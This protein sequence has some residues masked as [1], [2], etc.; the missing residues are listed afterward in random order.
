[1]PKPPD[2]GTHLTLPDDTAVLPDLPHLQ[3]E[4]M[5]EMEM[6][7][8]SYWQ[9]ETRAPNGDERFK[10]PPSEELQ[11]L[12][13]QAEEI[14][15]RVSRWETME[16]QLGRDRTLVDRAIQRRDDLWKE[17]FTDF[18]LDPPKPH[19]E[20]VTKQRNRV[21]VVNWTPELARPEPTQGVAGD[22]PSGDAE[23][24]PP[25]IWTRV[26]SP[27]VGPLGPAPP[28][29]T[30]QAGGPATGRG[31]AEAAMSGAETGPTTSQAPTAAAG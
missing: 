10:G 19:T 18:N 16:G 31:R 9:T 7:L 20:L 6:V 13:F 24:G 15:G 29:G 30:A 1:M 3:P 11:A 12:G 2:R 27:G 23:E 28:L 25:L 26:P 22:Q 8:R 5:R 14:T 4:E 17:A 21:Y